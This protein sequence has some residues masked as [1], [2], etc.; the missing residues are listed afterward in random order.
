MA[1]ISCIP[2]A[3]LASCKSRSLATRKVIQVFLAAANEFG[4]LFTQ[5]E[6]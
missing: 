1:G 2:G 4:A 3:P 5:K 6:Q